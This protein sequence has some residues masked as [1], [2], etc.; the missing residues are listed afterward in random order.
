[1]VADVWAALLSDASDLEGPE[2]DAGMLPIE[3]G[4]QSSAGVQHEDLGRFVEHPDPDEGRVEARSYRRAAIVQALVERNRSHQR[5][6]DVTVQSRQDLTL[7][8]FQA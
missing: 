3:M 8:H 5:A 7:L 4:V 2:R 1:M 6:A